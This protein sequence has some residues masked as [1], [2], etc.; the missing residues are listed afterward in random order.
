M[1]HR[2]AVVP[3]FSQL[4]IAGAVERIA[5]ELNHDYRHK[6]PLVIGVLKGSFIFMADLVRRLDFPLEIDFVRLASYG[7][8]TQTSGQ[9]RVVHGLRE[10]A[11]GRHLLVIEDIVDTGLT[12]AHLMKYLGGRHPASLK[13][14]A[15]A[16]KP[17]RR[18]VPLKIDYLGFTVPDRFVV[19]FGL[20]CD[21][22]FRNLPDIRV[23]EENE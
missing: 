10:A 17:A 20:D 3:L 1:P 6:H 21:E 15:L 18:R 22:E 16:D 12:V 4:Q 19:G 9:V 11:D 8:G 14:C 2:A 5:A 23:L 13:L 7:H